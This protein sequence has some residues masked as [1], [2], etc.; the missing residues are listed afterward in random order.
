MESLD[1]AQAERAAALADRDAA[2]AEA[3]RMA[4]ALSAAESAATVRAQAVEE[5]EKAMLEMR[6][7]LETSFRALASQALASNEQRFLTLAN[8]T[9]EKH[10]ETASGG[11]KEVL[12]P[13]QEAF[14]KLAESV[15]A[16][17]K[18][19]TED[20][21]ALTEQMRQIGEALKETQGV[22]GK[23]V[24]ALRAEPQK[25]GAWGEQTLRNVLEMAGLAPHIDFMEQAHHATEG[26]ALRPDVI[27]RLPGERCIVI[28]AKVALTAYLD[29]EDAS[30]PQ[31]RE[32]HMT[33][34][35]AQMRDHVK[36][37]AA[38]DYWKHV[39]NSAD[40]VVLFVPGEHFAAAAAQ[41][42]P[43]LYDYALQN[44]VIITTPTTLIALA[45]A[46]AYGWRQEEAARNAQ[47]IAEVGRSL[48]G[49]LSTMADKL[50]AVGSALETSMKR[51]NE[52]VGSVEARVMPAA[53]RF[54]DLGAGE[55]GVDIAELEPLDIAPRL[56][57]PPAELE[58]T[59]PR[60]GKKR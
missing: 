4:V 21:A 12:A 14:G 58:L 13:V 16:M 27:V 34:H 55:A 18:A 57:A 24:T 31:Q 60:A 39:P 2:R 22:A 44:N 29:A 48:Y 40:F 42:D 49:R 37:L 51:Y 5:R 23:L 33:R 59:P 17:D 38:K 36:K 56:P 35:A 45:K 1:A 9:F 54:K 6:A 26:G 46:V 11:V 25:R 43:G 47:E 3:A 32:V 28:D 41:R 53:R 20:K 7:E 52:L 8:E 30:D 50:T 10:K 19:R 15:G